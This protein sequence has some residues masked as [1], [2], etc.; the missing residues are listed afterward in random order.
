MRV[1]ALRRPAKVAVWETAGKSDWYSAVDSYRNFA[2]KS[3]LIAEG[4]YSGD[5]TR[6]V[7]I[8]LIPAGPG[9]MQ[10]PIPDGLIT[11]RDKMQELF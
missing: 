2:H 10:T 8:M 1:F 4:S 7:P 3:F 9:G 5:G 6:G 11:Y